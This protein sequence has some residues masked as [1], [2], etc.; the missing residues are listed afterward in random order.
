M[1]V[2]DEVLPKDSKRRSIRVDSTGAS[3]NWRTITIVIGVLLGGG[4]GGTT[5]LN[6]LLADSKEFKKFRKQNDIEHVQLEK[7]ISVNAENVKQLDDKVTALQTVQHRDYAVREARR[8][9]NEKFKCNIRN[10]ERCQNERDQA[11]ERIRRKNIKRLQSKIPQEVCS[12]L[13]CY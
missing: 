12:D 6:Y 2:H 3:M 5:Y 4:T 9:V 11:I 1:P 10:S 13:D 8:I 7:K